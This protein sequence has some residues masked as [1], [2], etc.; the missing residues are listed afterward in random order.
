MRREFLL[1][2]ETVEGLEQS[3]TKRHGGSGRD[4]PISHTW[5]RKKML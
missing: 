1:C 4:S 2:R 3:V 5:L